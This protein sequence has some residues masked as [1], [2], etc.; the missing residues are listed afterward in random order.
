MI[1]G[2][3]RVHINVSQEFDQLAC[4]MHS[5]QGGQVIYNCPPFGPLSHVNP[6]STGLPC[7]VTHLGSLRDYR[8]F[9]RGIYDEAHGIYLP[10]GLR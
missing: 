3:V 5:A 2:D 4:I 1:H 7:C 8:S 9:E 10:M 6:H